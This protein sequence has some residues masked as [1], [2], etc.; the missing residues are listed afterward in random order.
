VEQKWG[1]GGKAEKIK[2]NTFQRGGEAPP[3]FERR[4]LFKERNPL[5]NETDGEGVKYHNHRGGGYRLKEKPI[6]RPVFFGLRRG[7][8]SSGGS[9]QGAA[10]QGACVIR[11]AAK[12]KICH[13]MRG[14]NNRNG[15]GGETKPS[16]F[17]GGT[18]GKISTKEEIEMKGLQKNLARPGGRRNI[19][20]KGLSEREGKKGV[21]A[22]E[23]EAEGV[24]VKFTIMGT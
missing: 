24:S 14:G 2:K 17:K 10:H 19:L 21:V 8:K 13:V 9:V 23:R 18:L 3:L 4:I 7:R 11:R 20:T 16:Y 15:F 22:R 5:R 1:G 12:G 6:M